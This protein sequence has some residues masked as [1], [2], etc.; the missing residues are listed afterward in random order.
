MGPQ[1]GIK[2]KKGLHAHQILMRYAFWAIKLINTN[3]YKI[4]AQINHG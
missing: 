3:P 1:N 4:R 2:G